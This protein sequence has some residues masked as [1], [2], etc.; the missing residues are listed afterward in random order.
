MKTIFLDS[1]FRCHLTDD[2]SMRPVETDAFDGKCAT[3]I[4]GYRFVPAGES[5]ARADGAVFHG[6]MVAPAENYEALAKAQTQYE[7]DE[8]ARLADLGIPQEKDFT[9]TRNYPS[10]SFIGIRGELY[11]VIRSIPQYTS[12]I[13]GQNVIKTTVEHYLDT[14]KEGE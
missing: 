8:A 9:A 7:A 13:T 4:E 1:D 3:F 12:I 6:Q 10:E 2:G 5:W 14:L 11:E